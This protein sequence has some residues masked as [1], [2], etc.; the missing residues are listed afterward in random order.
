MI[1]APDAIGK[2]GAE[3]RHEIIN[4]AEEMNDR[5]STI[6]GLEQRGRDVERQ[7]ALHPII[8]ESLGGFVADDVFDLG[9]PAVV[10]NGG[11][12]IGNGGSRRGR[13]AHAW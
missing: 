4:K 13:R 2:P 3:E 6:F 7:N 12:R 9:R 1:T 10:L 5:R 8:T 11:G